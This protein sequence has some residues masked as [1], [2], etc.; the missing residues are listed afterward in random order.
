MDPDKRVHIQVNS[1]HLVASG[2]SD[3]GSIRTENQDSI[4]LDKGGNFVLLADGMG[5]HERGAEASQTI[6]D[7]FPE[8]LVPEKIKY[9]IGEITNVEGVP[10]EVI[11]LFSLIDKGV[12]KINK[13]LH[14]KNL[15][16]GLERHMGSTLVGL[17][18]VKGQYV[19]W[20][21][22]GDSRLYRYR[23][24]TLTQLTEDH[25]AYNEWKRRGSEGEEPAKNI[26]TRAIGPKEDV[27]P[28]INWEESRKDDLYILCSDGLNDMVNDDLIAGIIAESNDVD[29]TT[30]NLVTA[31]LDAGGKDNTS[32]IVCK[33]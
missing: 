22:A 23:D 10:P 25:S 20:F 15:E 31:A 24:N 13:T 4:Y 3:T 26:V 29:D 17:V 32:V 1:D 27:I 2:I 18:Q 6:I 16:E 21:H 12:N 5:G 9:E 7:L 33:T 8:Y 30:V 11:S 28:D 14:D 19:V